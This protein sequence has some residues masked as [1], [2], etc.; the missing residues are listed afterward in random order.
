MMLSNLQLFLDSKVIQYNQ[1]EFIENDPIV[2]PHQFS[3]KQDIEIMGFFAAILAWGQRKT[4]IQKCRELIERMDNAPF[5]FIQN[6]QE[7]DLKSLLGFKHRTF[8]DT[9]LLYFV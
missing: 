9:D 4:I 7:T 6:H 1:P 3:K 5:D 8:N 2:I